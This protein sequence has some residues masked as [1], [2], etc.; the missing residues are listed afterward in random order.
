MDD[1]EKKNCAKFQETLPQ[2]EM[3]DRQLECC[4]D[5]SLAFM[6]LIVCDGWCI[7]PLT[8]IRDKAA[9]MMLTEGQLRELFPRQFYIHIMICC[10]SSIIINQI[11]TLHLSTYRGNYGVD[12]K[13]EEKRSK[14]KA[15]YGDD[16][17]PKRNPSVESRYVH[18]QGAPTV[19]IFLRAYDDFLGQLPEQ[20]MKQIFVDFTEKFENIRKYL[21]FSQLIPRN[22]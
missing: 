17:E 8:R 21:S 6:F 20:L 7:G 9:W 22:S 12:F 13:A 14:G 2:R 19:H 4:T 3:L 18:P 10:I 11:M 16:W 5:E 1:D 15:V